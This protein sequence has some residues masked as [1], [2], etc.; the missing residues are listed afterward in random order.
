M[1]SEA[2]LLQQARWA[3]LAGRVAGLTGLILMVHFSAFD[4][5]LGLTDP[6]RGASISPCSVR[7]SPGGF[8]GDRELP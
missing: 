5:F 2:Y 3:A 4:G 7:A 8:L 6:A 1:K